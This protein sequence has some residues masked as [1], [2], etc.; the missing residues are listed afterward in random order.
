MRRVLSLDNADSVIEECFLII[1]FLKSLI[2]KCPLFCGLSL[3]LALVENRGGKSKAFQTG[4]I[5]DQFQV[6][7]NGT[8]LL[9]IKIITALYRLDYLSTIC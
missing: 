9:N 8:D 5:L 4:Y 3:I 6:V 2:S 7:L 1:S